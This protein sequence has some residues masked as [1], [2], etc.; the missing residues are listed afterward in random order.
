MG[1]STKKKSKSDEAEDATGFGFGADDEASAQPD[2]APEEEFKY[3]PVV[4]GAKSK[5]S[6]GALAKV[7]DS[8]R[9]DT[10]KWENQRTPSV[11]DQ[12]RAG[13]KTPKGKHVGDPLSLPNSS[14]IKLT[15]SSQRVFP[16]KGPDA[17]LIKN[18]KAMERLVT[19]HNDV[20]AWHE[21][22]IDYGQATDFV[23]PGENI[24]AALPI[25][26][27]IN[28]PALEVGKK[29]GT[30]QLILTRTADKKRRLLFLMDEV[31]NGYSAEE[32]HTYASQSGKNCKEICCQCCGC[33]FVLSHCLMGEEDYRNACVCSQCIDVTNNLNSEAK[34]DALQETSAAFSS[35][36]VEDSVVTAYSELWDRTKLE[37][38][39]GTFDPTFKMDASKT[40]ALTTLADGQT[41]HVMC[42]ICCCIPTGIKE[43]PLESFAWHVSQSVTGSQDTAIDQLYSNVFGKLPEGGKAN[44]GKAERQQSARFRTISIIF[45]DPG[46]G[47]KARTSLAVVHPSVSPK[48]IFRFTSLACPSGGLTASGS[49]EVV[50]TEPITS[51]LRKKTGVQES[52]AESLTPSFDNCCCF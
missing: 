43:T 24:L 7:Q 21:N 38:T 16:G 22:D 41:Q 8:A 20:N 9:P 34:Y 29:Y 26:G 25:I 18:E 28:M 1:G 10:L 51:A 52:V 14:R 47:N 2:A 44:Y 31:T 32:T 46:K 12:G 50:D 11:L 6:K 33:C 49:V 36:S 45:N 37:R 23:G 17:P 5:P 48:E 13:L 4:A 42:G 40:P 3:V 15:Q 30:G 35:L 27:Y 39:W 19:I